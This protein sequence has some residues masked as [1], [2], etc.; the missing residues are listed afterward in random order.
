[1]TLSRGP[2]IRTGPVQTQLRMKGRTMATPSKSMTTREFAEATGIPTA[3]ISKLIREGKLKARKEGKSWMIPQSQ[4]EAKVVRELGKPPKPT[5]A[6]KPSTPAAAPPPATAAKPARKPPA[7]S[8]PPPAPAAPV[9][10][11]APV[12]EP[13]VETR[14]EN[15][16]A[17]KTYSVSEFSA[18]TYLTQKGVSEWLRIGK[19][20]GIS[21]ENG[22]L[23]VL[24][25]NLQVPD[26]SRLVRK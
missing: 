26:I 11:P 16:P 2:V 23:R 22:E 3:T 18:M 9:P 17:Q 10:P 13:A 5:N 25:R 12:T 20:Q 24:A 6:K 4:L 8:P 19:L 21:Q 14:P 1:L 15:A 7:P